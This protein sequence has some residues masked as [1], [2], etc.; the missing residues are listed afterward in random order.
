MK[1]IL[2]N[3]VLL[4]FIY[5]CSGNR[6]KDPDV[7]IIGT[8]AFNPPYEFIQQD[9]IVGLD[10]DIINAI[11]ARLEKK[12]VI[13]N[14]NFRSLLGALEKK[15]VDLVISGITITNDRLMRINFSEPYTITNSAIIYRRAEAFKNYRDLNGKMVGAE[16]GTVQSQLARDLSKKKHHRVT[17]S[18][19]MK[20]LLA[21]LKLQKIDAILTEVHQAISFSNTDHNLAYFVLQDKASKFAIAINQEDIVLRNAI[22]N[23]LQH[24]MSNGTVEELHNKWLKM[25]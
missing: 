22:N 11:A 15:Q 10:I 4:L 1:Y 8:S 12:V 5:S 17:T 13:K 3:F 24:L 20:N 7:L 6:S 18:N 2:L 21:E 14:M 25:Q 23:A 16:I 9:Q 19:S